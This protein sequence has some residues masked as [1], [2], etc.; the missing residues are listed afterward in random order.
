MHVGFRLGK[1]DMQCRRQRRLL[2][3]MR[4]TSR[5]I[6]C[7]QY[8]YQLGFYRQ[9]I[10]T[11]LLTITP[12]DWDAASRAPSPAATRLKTTQINQTSDTKLHAGRQML[13]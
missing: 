2:L 3:P 10:W 1:S 7:N 6:V 8:T 13:R 9:L 4:H 12:A 11:E 5:R